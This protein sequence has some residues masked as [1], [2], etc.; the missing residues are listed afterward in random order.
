MKQNIL[1]LLALCLTSSIVVAQNIE[2]S[3]TPVIVS[4]IAASDFEGIA[5]STVTN[6]A[7][8]SR[9][10]T[11][12]R[13]VLEITD[14]WQTAVC[15]NVQCYFPTV[16]TENFVL[17]ANTAGTMDIHAYPN[18]VDGSAVVEIVVTDSDD[19]SLTMSN[20]YYFN[21]GPSST[22]EASRQT[23]KVYPNPSNGLF[24]VKGNKQIAN[25]EVFS[26]TGR[27]VKSFN[28]NDGQW[29]DISDLPTGTYLVRLIDRD[30]Q[31]LVT[32]L[33]NKL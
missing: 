25:V 31:Q 5:H 22:T 9:N 17:D 1:L 3:E 18:G 6:T 30:S 33:I 16:G 13:N 32:K 27:R 21:T 12:V 19:S 24:S 28:Y 23:I 7:D 15:D 11:W 2:F 26:L 14:G 29:Y 4:N 10:F 8:A 20:L